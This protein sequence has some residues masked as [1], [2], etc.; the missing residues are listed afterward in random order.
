MGNR[1]ESSSKS[2]LES[3]HQDQGAHL[4]YGKDPRKTGYYHKYH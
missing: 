2:H 3:D 1:L 4:L